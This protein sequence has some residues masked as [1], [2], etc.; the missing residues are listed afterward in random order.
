MEPGYRSKHSFVPVAPNRNFKKDPRKI[1]VK[2]TSTWKENSP[3]RVA[4]RWIYQRVL[5]MMEKSN[6][7]RRRASK[8]ERSS[9]KNQGE[10]KSSGKRGVTKPHPLRI[11][12]IFILMVDITRILVTV[13]TVR[14]RNSGHYHAPRGI[15]D[16]KGGI[17]NRDRANAK[18]P[19]ECSP[20][21]V[22]RLPVKRELS[23]TTINS[24]DKESLLF[25]FTVSRAT[26]LLL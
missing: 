7:N 25:R 14:V 18:Y 15:Y 24:V 4:S 3:R 5:A 2:L 26:Q 21:I 1:H 13:E 10:R 6:R 12:E 17:W 9:R 16:I 8:F 23:S 11:P 20:T 19:S 22:A